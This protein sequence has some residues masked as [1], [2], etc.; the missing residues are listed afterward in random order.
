MYKKINKIVASMIVFMMIIA[1]MSTVGIHIGEVFAVDSLENQGTV[2]NNANVNFD[3]YFQDNNSKIHETTKNIGEDN[4]I[5]VQ[6]AVKNAGYL[7]DTRVSFNDTNYTISNQVQSE[8]VAN[9][10]TDANAITLNQIDAGEDIKIEVPISFDKKESVNVSE[11]SKTSTVKLTGTYMDENGKERNIQ[12][13][14]SIGLNWAANLES[15]IEANVTKYVS[16]DA[17]E[18]K[19]LLMQMSV[20]SYIKDNALPIKQNKIEIDV[21]SI[22]GNLPEDVTVY[23]KDENS[24]FSNEN[25]SYDKQN[26]KLTITVENSINE[27]NEIAWNNTADEYVI[28]YNYSEE[29]L[30]TIGE[31]GVNIDI[32]INSQIKAISYEEKDLNTNY[33]NTVLLNEKIGNIADIKVQSNTELSKGYMYANYDTQEKIETAYTEKLTLDISKAELV[34]EI[35]INSKADKCV[36]DSK[37]YTGNTYYKNIQFSKSTF[38]KILGEEGTIKIYSADTLLNTIDKNTQVNENNKIV[39]DLNVDELEIVTSKPI[40]YGELTFEFEK[41]IKGETNYTKIQLESINK[42]KGQASIEATAG[43]T[44]VTDSNTET[45][46]TLVEP[47]TKAELVLNNTNFSTIVTNENIEMKA[48]LKTNSI[49][50]KLYKNPTITIDLPSYIETIDVK[51]VQL[52]FE[53][54]LTITSAD[55][56]QNTDGTKQIVIR[57]NGTQTKYSIDAISEG[58]NIVITADITTNNLT[59]NK[60]D[61]IKMICQNDKEQVESDVE[62]NFIAPVGIVTVNKI[63][64]YV[65]GAQLMALTNDESATLQVTTSAKTATAEIQVINNYSN[66]INNVRILGRTLAKDTTNTDT[67]DT[68]NNTFDAPMLGAINA[69]GMENVTIYY[70]TN[71][72]AT[73]DLND[74]SNGWTTQIVDYSSVKSYLIVINDY[75]MNIGDS[76]K[77]NYDVQIPENLGYSETINSVY[78]VYFDNVQENQIINDKA[79]SRIIT[80]STGIAPTIQ[81]ELSSYSQENSTVRTGQYIK[82]I[83]T[84]KNTGTIDA[85]NVNLNVVA[86]SGKLYTYRDENGNVKFTTDTSLITD[87]NKQLALEYITKHTEYIEDNYSSDYENTEDANKVISLGNIKAGQELKVEYEVVIDT[88]KVYKENLLSKTEKVDVDAGETTTEGAYDEVVTDPELVYPEATEFINNVSVIADDMQTSV[89]SNDYKLKVLAGNIKMTIRKDKFTEYTLIKGDELTYSAKLEQISESGDSKNIVV[90]MN[91]PEGLQI[92]EANFESM[93]ISDDVINASYVIDEANRTVTFTI[94]KLPVGYIVKCNVVTQVGDALGEISPRATATAEGEGTYYGNITTNNISKLEMSVSQSIPDNMYVKEDE[95]AIYTF[96]VK[97]TSDVTAG[98]FKFL[99]PIPE[100]MKFVEAE[101]VYTAENTQTIK[102]LVDGSFVLER[103]TFVAGQEVTI[104]MKL[105]AELLQTGETEKE[106]TTYATITATGIEEQKSNE[107]KT[108]I[109]YNEEAHKV[110]DTDDDQDDTEVRSK[111]SGIA[112]IDKNQNGQRDNDEEVLSGIEVRLLDNSTNEIVKD[113]D[114]QKEK[115]TTTTSSGEYTFS[116]LPDGKYLVIFV[117]NSAKYD[118]TQ[119]QKEDVSQSINSDVINVKMDINGEEKTV[120]ISDT[121]T[122]SGTNVRNIDIGLC[123]SEKS[124]L[125]LD[126]YISSITLTYGNTVK[127]YDYENSKLAKVEIPANNLSDATVIIEYKIVVTNEGAIGN[128]VRK[129]VDYLPTGMKFNSELNRDWYQSSNGDLYNS[130]LANNKLESGEKTEVTLTLTKKMSDTSVGIVNN[131]AEL[132]EI[133]NDEGIA[134]IDSTPANKINGEDDMSAADVV[135]SVKTGDAIVYTAIISAII[136]IVIGVSI[137]YIRKFVLKRM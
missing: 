37:E 45:E 74:N 12:K 60:Q 8:K 115:I 61:Q 104:K 9:V 117:Y 65:D 36:S 76:I 137:Y 42:I 95:D 10:Y 87:T 58:A 47:T 126:K 68:L 41:A 70:T 3:V 32:N 120:A 79:T 55:L 24:N 109:E 113:V 7:K 27:N 128:Y 85:Q 22:N 114:S 20:K 67:E 116:N 94:D 134:D 88:V 93:M 38:E 59:P 101:I 130:S 90:T 48:I 71:G 127:T 63:S 100:G 106:V 46:I 119:Y 80:L 78:T 17:N 51:N 31:D 110:V 69:N 122:V 43:E 86:P 39:I 13:E 62:V 18:Q 56:I 66:I 77:F 34:N 29:T 111:I 73:E 107:V 125:K 44:V 52:L 99:A 83:A 84:V 102:R 82:F 97:N 121:I 72:D 112:W 19:G 4:K 103:Y 54:E 49:Y 2:T 135:I 21:P 89:N 25:Y 118:L 26:S 131:N 6:I 14:I 91:I 57:L 50:N 16:Y 136:C 105:H 15:V 64:N 96:T 11:F 33:Q 98:N 133:Y 75:T 1:N 132:Y 35:K 23:N 40:T 30:K 124:D 129:I 92:K 108:I 53:D 81:V 5:V 28:T 123:E